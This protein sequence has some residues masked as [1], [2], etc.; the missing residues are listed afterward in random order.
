MSA[1][2]EEALAVE[3]EGA[4][5]EPF[6]VLETEALGVDFRLRAIAHFTGVE[7]WV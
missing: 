2:E 5:V 4:V 6:G 7:V 1:A 3:L